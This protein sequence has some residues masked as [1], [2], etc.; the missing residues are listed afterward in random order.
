MTENTTACSV[1]INTHC[2]VSKFELFGSAVLEWNTCC[3]WALESPYQ[4]IK[5]IFLI[6]DAPACQF[7]IGHQKGGHYFCWCCSFKAD[8]SA[9]LAYIYY[10]PFISVSDVV[11]KVLATPI[12]R[13]AAIEK[14]N[15]Y[16][17][18]TNKSWFDGRITS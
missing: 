7:E 15:T 3:N 4:T 14:K 11:E 17:W 5:Y 8:R 10:K 9:D 2:Q 16:F 13:S 12:G 1:R 18:E 6:G